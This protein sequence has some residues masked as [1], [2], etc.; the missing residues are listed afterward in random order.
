MGRHTEP[1]T[2][3][4]LDTPLRRSNGQEKDFHT[5]STQRMWILL[6][7]TSGHKKTGKRTPKHS[8]H[9]TKEHTLTRLKERTDI[10][11]VLSLARLPTCDETFL[12]HGTYRL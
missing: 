5:M 7:S 8:R 2:L 11:N 9:T 4:T 10:F 12:K 3:R 1:F 6:V